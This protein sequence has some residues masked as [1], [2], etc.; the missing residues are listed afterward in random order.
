MM[1]KQLPILLV[2]LSML[3]S[4]STLAEGFNDN[5]FQ[6]G[7]ST[8]DYSSLEYDLL[9]ALPLVE[10]IKHH[11]LA[12]KIIDIRASVDLG[13]NYSIIGGYAR[14]S[15][16]W[17]D[18]YTEWGKNWDSKSSSLSLGFGKN[19][20]LASR[21]F[22]TAIDEIDKSINH[23]QKTKDALLST[24]RNLRLANDKA[25]DLTLKRLTRNKFI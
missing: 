19:F 7:F 21:K 2:S 4:S 22:S 23:L 12:E 15:G 5:Y 14:E 1:N 25:Q 17:S 9:A 11:D 24:D 8:S 18:G 16:D 3:F 20:D 10:K 13:N 6:L